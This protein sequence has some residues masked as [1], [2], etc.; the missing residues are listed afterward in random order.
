M[1]VAAV[2]RSEYGAG[3]GIVVVEMKTAAAEAEGE[4]VAAV[5][6]RFV[7]RFWGGGRRVAAG[8]QSQIDPQNLGG[9][10]LGPRRSRVFF[11]Y[12]EVSRK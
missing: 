7:G 5:M 8:G 6:V 11:C 10:I 1:V 3:G 4:E 2:M 9:F 12:L